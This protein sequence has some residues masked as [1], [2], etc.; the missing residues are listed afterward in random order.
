MIFEVQRVVLP[1][2]RELVT[3]LGQPSAS[4]L[5]AA[6][7]V[8]V[9]T[10]HR[11]AAADAAPRAAMLALYWLSR[12]GQAALNAELHQRAML[13]TAHL[14]SLRAENARL[15]REL[16]RLLALGDFGSAN[17]PSWRETAAELMA[18]RRG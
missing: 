10:V 18:A 2:F 9:G 5:A 13:Y 17:A 3:D 7:G 15:R 1:T 12:P 11:W 14:E 8:H 4:V 16:A 6:L